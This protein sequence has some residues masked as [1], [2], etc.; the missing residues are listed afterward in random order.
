MSK[1][2][3]STNWIIEPLT[4]FRVPLKVSVRFDERPLLIGS[5]ELTR[6][7]KSPTNKAL[8]TAYPEGSTDGE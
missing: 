8:R 4:L 3:I 6:G 1:A 2:L 5:I 7:I